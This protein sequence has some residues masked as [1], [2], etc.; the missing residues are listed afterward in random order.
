MVDGQYYLYIELTP[1]LDA[2]GM[3]ENILDYFVPSYMLF[4]VKFDIE[5]G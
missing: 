5:I 1:L 2:F 4:D 3:Q